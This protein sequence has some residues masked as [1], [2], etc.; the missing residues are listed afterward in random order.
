MENTFNM[1]EKIGNIN[2][3]IENIKKYQMEILELKS[4]LSETKTPH[5]SLVAEWRWEIRISEFIYLFI[6]ISWRLITLQYCSG[7]CH[8]LKWISHGFTCVPH[9]DP[10]SHL[11]LHPWISEFKDRSTEIIWSE[12]E[13]EK[14]LDKVKQTSRKPQS[15][16]ELWN[17]FERFNMWVIGVPEEWSEGMRQKRKIWR[18]NGYKFLKLG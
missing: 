15:F 8:T 1:N 4:I 17:N 2:G 14:R 13:K 7:C 9:P 6:F 18:N 5:M 10:P 11:P 3:E 12:E 16:R